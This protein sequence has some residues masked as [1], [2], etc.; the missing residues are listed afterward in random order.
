MNIVYCVTGSI[1]EKLSSKI[2]KKLEES[3]HKV[4]TI[5]TESTLYFPQYENKNRKYS[6]SCINIE[7]E[8]RAYYEQNKVWHI[9]V[10]NWAD[11][12]LIAPCT[13]NTI[14]KIVN[15]IC[16]TPQLSLI[17]AFIGMN[18]KVYI[19]P[20]MNTNMYNNLFVQ[21]NLY[22]LSEVSYIIT[23]TVK[24][25][26]C[27]DFGI[28]ALA[29][30]N[31]IIDAVNDYHWGLPLATWHDDM[32]YNGFND[33]FYNYLPKHDEPGS[34][35]A[36]RKYDIHTG[37]DI[38]CNTKD[39]VIAV[40]DGEVIDKGAF[41]GKQVNTDWWNDT[42][43]IVVKG[44]SGYVLYGE[45]E[46]SELK[47]GNKVKKGEFIS[48]V[49]PVLDYDKIRK[50]IRNHSNVMLHLELYKEYNKPILWNL[51]EKRDKNLLD[52]TPYLKNCTIS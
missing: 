27:G 20:S 17:T 40:E 28:G 5:T 47:I 24:E 45:I 36:V 35:G 21:K 42:D 49:K 33:S 12:L 22:Y 44:K 41:T 18:K 16:D 51:N 48:F 14:G 9:D 34:F 10:A 46:P 2:I 7:D 11:I 25:L 19:A 39:C 1:S 30:I 6:P 50:D 26:A 15:G 52:P 4:Y 37:V 8:V 23:P 31:A 38:Y 29:D 3:K 13:A 43:Y 32:I